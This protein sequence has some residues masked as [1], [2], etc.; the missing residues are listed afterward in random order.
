VD[1]HFFCDP[2]S[3][4]FPHSFFFPKS[5]LGWKNQTFTTFGLRSNKF[6][7]IEEDCLIKTITQ[8]TKQF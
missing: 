5:A 3:G 7:K 1:I 6:L 2:G 8:I 4:D